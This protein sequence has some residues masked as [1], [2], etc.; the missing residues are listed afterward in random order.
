MAHNYDGIWQSNYEYPSSSR[1]KTFKGGHTVRLHQKGNQL[2]AESLPEGNE[3]YVL[4]R[5]V[6]DDGVAT[7]SWQEHTNPEGHYEG[8]IYH[9]AIQLK[10]DKSGLRMSGKWLGFGKDGT[11]NSGPWELVRQQ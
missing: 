9:G 4:I 8:A 10:A 2:V 5:L 1:G 6:L 3:S 7:G 11:V